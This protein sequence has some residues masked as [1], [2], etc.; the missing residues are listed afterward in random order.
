MPAKPTPTKPTPT[1]PMPDP[2]PY[3]SLFVRAQDGLRL[4]ARVYGAAPDARRPV[5]CLPG[6]TR[7]AE[8][9]HDLALRL[10]GDPRAPRRVLAL[11]YRGRGLSEHDRDWR[12]Y[13]VEVETGDVMAVLAAAGV[14]EA[15]FVGTSR[16]GLIAM[17]LAAARPTL[18]AGVALVDIGPVIA[19]KGLIRIRSAL[20][21]MP[22]PKT[23]GE[24][25]EVLRRLN[26]A[27][28]PALDEAGWRK[29]ARGI[30]R[31][32]EGGALALSY[33]P[34]L[35]KTLEA[36][37]LEQEPPPLWPLFEALAHVPVLVVRGALSDVLSP[38]TLAQMLERHPRIASHE[39]PGQG[40]APLLDGA[41]A[42]R[43]AQF[44]AAA[45]AG[46]FPDPRA[47]P[48]GEAA[49]EL[50]LPRV[51][52]SQATPVPPPSRE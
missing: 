8:D 32:E 40:H 47:T 42:E 51:N 1:K 20:S 11:D 43:I 35:L 49:G 34:A 21:K 52:V 6:L 50:R 30:W 4:H 25:I 45:E 22:R 33:D 5:V 31:E 9:F 28:F 38:A 36:L 10:A 19:G 13:A 27:Q 46:D 17:A 14:E 12:R 16:G 48:A 7:N 26:D 39:V 37:D 3:R 18:L 44:I 41:V 29:L 15:I 23:W 2:A 24:A